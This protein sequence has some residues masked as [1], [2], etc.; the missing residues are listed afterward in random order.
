MEKTKNKTIEQSRFRK[1]SPMEGVGST[2]GRFF[3]EKRTFEFRSL[4][5]SGP[6]DISVILVQRITIKSSLTYGYTLTVL[7]IKQRRRLHHRAVSAERCVFD[8]GPNSEVT[9]HSS[10]LA[11][12]VHIICCL[13]HSISRDNS[14]QYA[15][16]TNTVRSVAA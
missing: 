15:Y 8:L 6:L 2:M 4:N 10:P 11:G 5:R 9:R 12:P 16:L 7:A 13:M 3:K 1:G 14:P